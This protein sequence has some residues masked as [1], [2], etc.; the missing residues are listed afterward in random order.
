[1]AAAE[2]VGNSD[3]DCMVADNST[4]PGTMQSLL[5]Q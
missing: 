1:M 2:A 5:S 3:H 4:I